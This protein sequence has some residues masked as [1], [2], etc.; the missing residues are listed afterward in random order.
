MNPQAPTLPSLSDLSCLSEREIEVLALV[1]GFLSNKEIAFKLY[2]SIKTVQVHVAH[3]RRKLQA[4]NRA[5]LAVVA[6]KYGL[7][8]LPVEARSNHRTGYK[9]HRTRRSSGR[10]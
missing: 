10:K 9:P 3:L 8:R 4:R 6:A 7:T 1:G 5:H 2:R